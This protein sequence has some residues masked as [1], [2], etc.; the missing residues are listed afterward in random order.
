MA[1]SLKEN[2][3]YPNL[4]LEIKTAEKNLFIKLN[5]EIHVFSSENSDKYTS[6]IVYSHNEQIRISLYQKEIQLHNKYIDYLAI[7]SW[8][9][10]TLITLEKFS[11]IHL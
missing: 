9:K 4:D 5:N 2:S 3:F 6:N 1:I 10:L 8:F 11:I 7:C